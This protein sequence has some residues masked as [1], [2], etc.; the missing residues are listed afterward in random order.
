MAIEHTNKKI[1][2]EQTNNRL[3]CSSEKHTYQKWIML[4]WFWFF[5]FFILFGILKTLPWCVVS[6]VS[7]SN[8]NSCCSVWR[9]LFSTLSFFETL[10]FR[11]T[12]TAPMRRWKK[13]EK[14]TSEEDASQTH[15]LVT[16]SF[17]DK[18]CVTIAQLYRLVIIM[19][20][21]V[22]GAFNRSKK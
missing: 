7:H 15:F 21:V 11:S 1:S 17:V 4:F 3:K 22:R 16:E 10:L 12:L 2:K 5:Y 18:I 8:Q 14:N 13:N 19:K 6:S 20:W 9:A